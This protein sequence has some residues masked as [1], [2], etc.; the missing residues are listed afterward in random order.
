MRRLL[1]SLLV[2]LVQA[3]NIAIVVLAYV[4][5]EVFWFIVCVGLVVAAE[6]LFLEVRRVNRQV[7]YRE[8]SYGRHEPFAPGAPVGAQSSHDRASAALQDRLDALEQLAK[9]G[10]ISSRAYENARDSYWV[11]HIMERTD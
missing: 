2:V 3:P 4:Q 9:E 8:A 11:R 10:K 1:I 6:L 5:V 7:A